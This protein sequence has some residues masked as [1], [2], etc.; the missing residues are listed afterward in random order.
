VNSK[1]ESGGLVA[2]ASQVLWPVRLKP[3]N[4]TL[5]KV[6]DS[7]IESDRL[8]VLGSKIDASGSDE[9][10]KAQFEFDSEMES[11][12]LVHWSLCLFLK[13]RVSSAYSEQPEPGEARI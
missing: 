3:A 4:P 11:E 5:S 7:N 1:F 13:L 9:S 2:F 8:E 6:S 10:I 12:T